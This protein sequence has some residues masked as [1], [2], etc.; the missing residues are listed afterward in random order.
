MIEEEKVLRPE[1]QITPARR[2]LPALES[3]KEAVNAVLAGGTASGIG[4]GFS[5]ASALAVFGPA[6]LLIGLGSVFVAGAGLVYTGRAGRHLLRFGADGS[7]VGFISAGILGLLG[8]T[9]PILTGLG[10]AGFWQVPMWLRQFLGATTLGLSLF[11]V[12][13]VLRIVAQWVTGETD[14]IEDR[15]DPA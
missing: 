9:W 8:A 7:A 11:V 5:M 6:S 10:M 13:Y 1:S 12:F 3:R 15:L 2:L 4:L 14:E